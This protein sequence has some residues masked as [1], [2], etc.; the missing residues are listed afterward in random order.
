MWHWFEVVLVAAPNPLSAF[1][2]HRA[3][4]L[5]LHLSGRV[6]IQRPLQI[7]VRT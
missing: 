5:D 6:F 2:R 4:E 7:G 3:T 1:S